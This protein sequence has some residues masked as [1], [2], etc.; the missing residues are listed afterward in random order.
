MGLFASITDFQSV[1]DVKFAKKCIISAL[2]TDWQSVIA[3][4]FNMNMKTLGPK[5]ALLF[6]KLNDRDQR[7]FDLATAAEL[8]GVDRP[9]AVDILHLASKRGL[10]TPIQRGIYNLV[11]FE[12]GSTSFHLENRY[13]IVAASMLGKPYYLSHSSALDLHNVITQPTFEIYV[14]ITSRLATR[15]QGGARVHFVNTQRPHF[16][17]Y[18]LHDLGDNQKVFV[19]DLERSLVDGFARSKYCGGMIEVAKAVF[20]GKSRIDLEKLVAY[21]RRMNVDAIIRRLGFVLE[22]LGLGNKTLLANLQTGLPA[23]VVKLDQELPLEG[24]RNS[25]WGLRL[26]LS[27]EEIM[28][29]VSN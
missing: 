15:N 18:A 7:V 17:G 6:T 9:H 2:E 16:F 12:L 26:N 27:A 11:P 5:T 20:I 23:A 10:I 28:K 24:A 4:G 21:A 19:S 3:A 29:A 14:S 8:M 22:T 25:K 13:V 1:I